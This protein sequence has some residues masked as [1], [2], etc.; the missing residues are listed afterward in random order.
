MRGA[1]GAADADAASLP[2][3]PP[4]EGGAAHEGVLSMLRQK[5]R[6]KRKAEEDAFDGDY[7]PLDPTAWRAKIA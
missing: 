4:T 2:A 1:S 3:A 5:K 6:K 7:V